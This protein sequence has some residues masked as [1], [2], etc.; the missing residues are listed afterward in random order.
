MENQLEGESGL[1]C[2][3]AVGPYTAGRLGAAVVPGNGATIGYSGDN[4]NGCG[5]EVKNHKSGNISARV[6]DERP[7]TSFQSSNR[8]QPCEVR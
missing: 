6:R 3:C 5:K 4:Q 2:D 1:M 7:L 8:P